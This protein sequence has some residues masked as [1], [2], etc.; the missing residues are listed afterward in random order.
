VCLQLCM[1]HLPIGCSQLDS[2]RALC[3]SLF[4]CSYLI[5]LR[6]GC[7]HMTC[8]CGFEFCFRCGTPYVRDGPSGS[9]SAH[10]ACA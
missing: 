10:K 7:N 2:C 4:A 9:G 3:P 5:E 1:R 8:R 6:E